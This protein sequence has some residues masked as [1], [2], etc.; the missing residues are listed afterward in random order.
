MVRIPLI[1]LSSY[2]KI[3]I[4]ST[5]KNFQ[6]LQEIFLFRGISVKRLRLVSR[7]WNEVVLSLPKARLRLRLNHGRKGACCNPAKFLDTI[8]PTLSSPKLARWICIRKGCSDHC[9]ASA[10]ELLAPLCARYSDTIR[11]IWISFKV[12]ILPAVALILAAGCPN[13]KELSVSCPPRGS[14]EDATQE[15]WEFNLPQKFKLT[16]ISLQVDDAPNPF[17]QKVLDSA[18]NLKTLILYANVYPDLGVNTKLV[19]LCYYGGGLDEADAQA[20]FNAA[21]MTRLISQV[22]NSLKLLKIGVNTNFGKYS[23]TPQNFSLPETMPKL[24]LYCNGSVDIFKSRDELGGLREAVRYKNLYKIELG[25]SAVTEKGLLDKFLEKWI[26]S[27]V[28]LVFPGVKRLLFHGLSDFSVLEKLRKVC[29]AV[30]DLFLVTH[31]KCGENGGDDEG[32]GVFGNQLK[33]L[34]SMGGLSAIKLFL[35][36]PLKLS[37]AVKGFSDNEELFKGKE[38]SVNILRHR[39][40]PIFRSQTHPLL[41]LIMLSFR[42]AR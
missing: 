42:R 26:N 10:G 32:H 27:E 40:T 30:T 12:S 5:L 28:P 29:P 25:S 4:F 23:P 7:L 13:L 14:E 1:V 3:C 11:G 6:I 35:T 17:I 34:V 31:A 38:G 2:F 9:R 24:A 19:N 21:E 37:D 8:F 33:G 36:M 15:M 18:P 22:G 41:I 39:K 16:Y 20:P